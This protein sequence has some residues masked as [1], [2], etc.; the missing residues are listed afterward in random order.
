MACRPTRWRCSTAKVEAVRQFVD[1]G[2]WLGAVGPLPG[3]GA[4]L[5]GEAGMVWGPGAGDAVVVPGG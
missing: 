3:V 1:Q 2:G 5:R 4:M